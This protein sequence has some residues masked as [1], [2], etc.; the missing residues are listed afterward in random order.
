[1]KAKLLIDEVE[2]NLNDFVEQFLSGTIV[3]A[4]S[5]LRDINKD[6]KK[7]DLKITR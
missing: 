1:L 7:L 6:W 3:G 4:I 2:I 5:S